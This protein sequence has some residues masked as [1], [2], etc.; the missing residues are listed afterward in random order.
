MNILLWVLQIVAAVLFA[1]VGAA[2]LTRPIPKLTATMPWVADTPAPVVRGIGAAEILGAL[3]LILPAATGI[4]AILSPTAA[5]GLGLLMLLAAITHARRH[6]PSAIPVNA[7]LLAVTAT[8]AWG[9]F[10]PYAL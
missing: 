5:A 6:E 10:G 9:R 4:A 3:A 1:A 2:K 8:I 7:A